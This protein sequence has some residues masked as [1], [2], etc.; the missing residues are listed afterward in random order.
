[1]TAHKIKPTITPER[2]EWF[3][4]YHEKHLSWGAFHVTLED[5][6]YSLKVDQSYSEGEPGED[7]AIEWFNQLTQSQRKRLELKC[8]INQHVFARH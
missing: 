8:R 1:M 4:A 3:K 7:E 5:G 2:I 6:N